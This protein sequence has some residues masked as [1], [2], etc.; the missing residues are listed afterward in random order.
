M[1]SGTYFHFPAPTRAHRSAQRGRGSDA[2][3]D[4][5]CFRKLIQRVGS[6]SHEVRILNA[7]GPCR[8]TFDRAFARGLFW[9]LPPQ[10]ETLDLMRTSDASDG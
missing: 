4:D 1:A 9:G 3:S 8:R 10:A 5:G 2:G 7:P 6:I